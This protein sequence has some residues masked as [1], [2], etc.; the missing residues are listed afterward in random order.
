[1]NLH[2]LVIGATGYVGS[3]VAA[4]LRARGHQVTGFAR[5]E[6]N[7]NTLK[8]AGLGAVQGSLDDLDGLRTLVGNYDIVVMAG[9]VPFDVEID[10]MTAMVNGC[11]S[12]K[13]RYLLFTSGTGVL[14][15]EAKEG[16]WSQYTFAEDDPFPF[17]AREN[18]ALRIRTETLVRE[19]SNDTLS[20]F[21]IRPPLIWGNAGSIQ[22]PQIFESARQTGNAC[23]LGAGLNLYSN[24]HVEDLAEAFCLAIEKGTPGALYHT[25]SGEADF[26]EIAE[27]VAHVTGCGTKSLDYEGAVA[28]W[29]NIWVDLALAVNSRSIAKRAVEDLGWSPRHRDLIDDI[30]NGSY[31]ESYKAGRGAFSWR[32]HG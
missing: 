10:L 27:A 24:V 32:S 14:S 30:R 9:M 2:A 22:V 20:T 7:V 12:G 6:K 23:Y 29:G 25:V 26:R 1:M 5:N 19:A 17:P 21:V 4:A 8:A 16:Q 15:I 28:L 13:T 31:L 18:R 11:Q 3:H